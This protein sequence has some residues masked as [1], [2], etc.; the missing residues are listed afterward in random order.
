MAR[1][2]VSLQNYVKLGKSDS[3]SRKEPKAISQLLT[4][5]RKHL[6]WDT[7]DPFATVTAVPC[8]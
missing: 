5:Q 2:L 7:Q 3:E 4:V 8:E 6:V 1:I